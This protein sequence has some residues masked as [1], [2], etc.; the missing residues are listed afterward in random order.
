MLRS[1][2]RSAVLLFVFA[3]ACGG[4]RGEAARLQPTSATASLAERVET[5]RVRQVAKQVAKVEAS[6]ATKRSMATTQSAPLPPR[7]AAQSDTRAEPV[8]PPPVDPERELE[9]AFPLYG[10]AF[11]LLAQVFS[12]PSDKAV[13]TGY[14]RR[15]SAFRAK[16]AV[17][18]RGCDTQWHEILPGGFVCA[19]RG[20]LL[21][22]TP[23]SFAGAPGAP[24]LHE[25]LPYAYGKTLAPDLPQFFRQPSPTQE[26]QAS[27]L[28]AQAATLRARLSHTSAKQPA[29]TELLAKTTGDTTSAA[30]LPELVRMAMQPGFY[31]SFDGNVDADAGA[32]ARTVR[33]A[34]VRA[35]ALTSVSVPHLHGATLHAKEALPLG[36]VYRKGAARMMRNPMSGLLEANGSFAFMDVLSLADE[37]VVQAGKR[38]RMTRDG[39][40]VAEDALRIVASAE[41]PPLVPRQARWLSIQLSTQSLVAFEGDKPVFATLVSTGKEQHETPTGIFRIQSKHV[42]TTMDGEA[43]TDE[44]YSIED[45]PWT[46]YFSGGIALH[47]AFWHTQFGR[48]RSHGCVNL[49]PAD[50]RWLFDWTTPGLPAGFHGVLA[51]REN[52]GTYV[53]IAP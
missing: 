6:S 51:T 37:S 21:G 9:K 5:P 12:E 30:P 2:R 49:A 1:V 34:Y 4:V 40:L 35:D 46:M 52:P 15:G 20:F 17:R 53:V 28:L 10:M 45:V 13:V 27:A 31:V 47:A 18:G 42:S 16:P 39:A 43:G 44:A 22:K 8:E 14:L 33:G 19:G 48:V 7:A 26:A 3:L 50:A 23:Q 38:Y 11:H 36:L 32:F 41:R 25:D 24:V 29:S